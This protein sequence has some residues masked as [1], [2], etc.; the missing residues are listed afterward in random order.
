MKRGRRTS[1]WH[2]GPFIA[3]IT[4]PVLLCLHV[5]RRFLQEELV[6]ESEA[7]QQRHPLG[8]DFA[9]E[10]KVGEGG[11]E[12]TEGHD[13]ALPNLNHYR[14]DKVVVEDPF[15]Y[16][17]QSGDGWQMWDRQS[18]PVKNAQDVVCE[19][20]T[21][22]SR[23]GTTKMCT[24]PKEQDRFVSSEIQ[25]LGKWHE[26]GKLVEMW[27]MNKPVGVENDNEEDEFFVEIGVNI[28]ACLMEMLLSTKAK[29]IGFEANPRNAAQV[30]TTLMAQPKDMRDRV[31]FFPIGLGNKVTTGV[32][33]RA[34]DNQGNSVVNSIVQ[35]FKS[36]K[37][38]A[39]IP[40][41]LERLD[42]ILPG[43]NKQNKNNKA[44]RL[45]K[46]DVQG[47]ECNVMDAGMGVFQSAR[48]LKTEVA[49]PFLDAQNCSV[50][51]LLERI[52]AAG[53][54]HPPNN[55]EAA[56]YYDI[57]VSKNP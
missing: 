7:H 54:Q 27:K 1:H 50:D 24:Y 4:I 18:I 28:G 41:Q 42:N 43:Y 29:I 46:M 35:D 31:A 13:F 17:L 25:R 2:K 6:S 15:R 33:H 37:M 51:G 12:L 40:I 38:L 16:L 47:F 34:A 48:A 56:A 23:D 20:A 52:E 22:R 36:Q 5:H 11:L 10:S 19:W 44:I 26:C 21:I 9:G 14:D 39:P 32:I 49:K 30:A 57:H 3:V 45:I 8:M 53:F 55:G